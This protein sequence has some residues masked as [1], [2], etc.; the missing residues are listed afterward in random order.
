MGTRPEVIKLA[1]VVRELRS[2][3][4]VQVRVV[5]TAQHRELL[6]QALQVFALRP[7]VDLALMQAGQDL[8]ALTGRVLA[9]MAAEIAAQRPAVVVVQ[10]DTTT[11]FAASLAAFYAGVPIAHVEAGLRTHDAYNPFPEELNR[12]L[13]APLARWHFAPTERARQ[14]LLREG[15]ADEQI[16]VSGNTV[17]DALQ[18]IAA[19]DAF[20]ATALPAG[21]DASRRLILV[22]LHRRE[23]WG[24]PLTAMCE[25]LADLSRKHQDV[26][27]IFPVHLNP[28]VSATVE[29]SLA[30]TPRVHLIGPLDYVTFLRVMQASTLVL[31]DSGGV[32]EEA[33]V[34]GCPVLVLRDTT[35]RPEAIE[36]GVAKRVGT[37]RS[38]IVAAA[39]ALLDDSDAYRR[40]ARIASP[41]G[42]G[43][44]ASRIADRLLADAH[45]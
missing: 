36:A 28:A 43:R 39:S 25:A 9:A 32:Q 35:E 33:P 13:T 26:E 12:R 1:P 5:A 42:D 17:V 15:V 10:G 6:D 11:V 38:D 8:A 41:F 30:G 31:T 18:W 16:C 22:T 3:A 19:T 24:Q 34:F 23:S 4:G 37:A 2:R 7:D 44:A 29:K 40:M 14:N 21:I 45:L 20:H 27:V